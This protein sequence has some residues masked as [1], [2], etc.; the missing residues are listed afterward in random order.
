MTQTMSDV[1]KKA[2][3]SLATVSYALNH[4]ARI[5]AGTAERVRAAARALGYALPPPGVRRGP[6]ASRKVSAASRR[7]VLLCISKFRPV[8]RAPV[9]A[10]ALEG[11]EYESKRQDVELTINMIDTVEELSSSREWRRGVDGVILF[12]PPR[13]PALAEVVGSLPCVSAMGMLEDEERWDRVTV[14]DEAIGRLAGQW[15]VAR[16][17]QACASV[18]DSRRFLRE[19]S[20]R[21]H[22]EAAGGRVHGIESTLVVVDENRH[23][24]NRQNMRKVVDRLAAL[25]P[26]PT[27]VF[28]L[29]DMLTAAAYPILIEC[30]IRPGK[31]IDIVS[32]NNEEILLMNLHP[33][34]A[35]VDTRSFH[36]GR[37][38]V[39]QLLWRLDNPDFTPQKILIAP[40]MVP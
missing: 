39:A 27:A 24:V 21:R 28:F 17:H 9:Y 4:D 16:K 12:S 18:S 37:R 35:V 32:C 7:V 1:A 40:V 10:N 3:V 22:V 26:R 20:F 13:D 25:S 8:L 31:D 36:V 19:S 11:M 5:S 34:P 38:A 23:A 30:G 29:T 33:K 15:V 6:R 2:K 14:D